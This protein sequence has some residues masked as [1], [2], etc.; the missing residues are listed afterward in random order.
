MTKR[1]EFRSLI[2][3][4]PVIAAVKD[5]EGLKASLSSDCSIIF[6][7]FGDVSDIKEIV[8]QVKAAG[9]VAVVHADLIAGLSSKE[10]SIDYLKEEAGADGI[11]STKPALIKHAGSLGMYTVLRLFLID[12]MAVENLSKQCALAKPDCIEIL[13]GVMPKVIKRI[14]EKER[15]PLIAGGLI[16]DKEDIMTALKA[17]AV[18]ISTT[19]QELWFA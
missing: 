2:E 15:T 16:A 11:I 5:M 9:K 4:C 17:G 14:K 3:D 13:P 1:A 19:R 12:S 18:S 7:L 6:I 8:E 10:I